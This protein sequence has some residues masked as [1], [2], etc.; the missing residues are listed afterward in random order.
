MPLNEYPQDY[1]S[2]S[3]SRTALVNL[4]G[5]AA[6]DIESLLHLAAGR[7]ELCMFKSFYVGYTN[8]NIAIQNEENV[9]VTFNLSDLGRKC[10]KLNVDVMLHSLQVK[11]DSIGL[12]DSSIGDID[13]VLS[14]LHHGQELDHIVALLAKTALIQA[15]FAHELLGVPRENLL[16]MSVCKLDVYITNYRH[17]NRLK[18]YIHKCWIAPY[19]VNEQD[20]TF[21]VTSKILLEAFGDSGVY[22]ELKYLHDA[23]V[24]LGA[25]MEAMDSLQSRLEAQ[26]IESICVNAESRN[27][28]R[29]ELASSYSPQLAELLLVDV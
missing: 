23:D 10:A 22:G 18:R 6:M 20:H 29:A 24:S 9:L 12:D 17:L 26:H 28:L 3:K 16:G 1:T 25:V 27:V 15:L 14:M 7:P 4:R 5:I 11:A 13:E 8:S 2:T 19:S 21:D